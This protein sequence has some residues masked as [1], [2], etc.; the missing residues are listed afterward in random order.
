MQNGKE[1][2]NRWQSRC[3]NAAVLC[4]ILTVV[5]VSHAGT[6]A[7][8]PYYIVLCTDVSGSMNEHDPLYRDYEGK[9]ST[10]RDDAQTTFLGLLREF[11]SETYVGVCKFTDR[12]TEALPGGT[13][14]RAQSKDALLR[15]QEVGSDWQDLREKINTQRSGSGGTRIEKALTWAH[16]RISSAREQH[17][18][19]GHGIV[20]L[21]SDGD[22]DRAESRSKNELVVNTAREL[23]SDSIS[24]YPIIINRA[25]HR[26][27]KL[28]QALT[29]EDLAAEKLMERVGACSRTQ[30][31]RITGT[32]DLLDIFLDILQV[33]PTPSPIPS[34]ES[35]DVS[36]HHRTVVFIGPALKSVV[37][38]PN[39]S[40]PPQ[41]RHELLLKN[42]HDPNSAIELQVVPLARWNIFVLR[43][44]PDLD[45]IDRYWTGTWQPM[46]ESAR[47]DGRVYLITDFLARLT[48]E[49]VSPVWVDERIRVGAL[50]TERPREMA[51]PNSEVPPL[52]SE[53]LSFSF[54]TLRG[55]R[56]SPIEVPTD[57]WDSASKTYW[58]QPFQVGA[59]GDYTV[60]CDCF[61]HSGVQPV[62]LDTFSLDLPVEPPPLSM[63][64]RKTQ[65]EEVVFPKA[66][67]AASEVAACQGGEQL[68]A[69]LQI[70][71]RY[72]QTRIQAGYLYLDIKPSQQ[73]AFQWDNDRFITDAFQLPE[74]DTRLA[75]FAQAT[76]D[77][78]GRLRELRLPGNGFVFPFNP[79]PLRLA[80][81][82][83]DKRDALWWGERHRQTVD[84][85]VYPVFDESAETITGLFP[86]DLTQASMTFFRGPDRDSMVVPLRCT[87]ETLTK[88][89]D[90]GGAQ[91]I[92]GRYRFE[93]NEPI[94]PSRRCTIDLGTVLT[95]LN[96]AITSY[97][98]VDPVAQDI[99]AYGMFQAARL[100]HTG[101]VADTVYTNEPISFV[102]NWASNQNVEHIAFAVYDLGGADAQ[103]V[104]EV[105][106]PLAQTQTHSEIKHAIGGLQGGRNY[107]VQIFTTLTPKGLEGPLTLALSG[108][109]FRAQKRHLELAELVVKP[110]LGENVSCY[111]LEAI[112]LPLQIYFTGYAADNSRHRQRLAEF[113]S[114]CRL[115]VGTDT[116]LQ[117]DI[118]ETIEWITKSS[119]NAA[120]LAKPYRM[121][122]RAR[123]TPQ[124][125]GLHTL[126]LS[127]EFAVQ[128]ADNKLHNLHQTSCRLPVKPPRF[129]VRVEE[130]TPRINTSLFDSD[131]LVAGGQPTVP[132]RNA[133]AT[134]LRVYLDFSKTTKH[135]P[136]LSLPVG[137]ALN[138]Q[139]P[140]VNRS[141]RV[142]Y[143]EALVN[144]SHNKLALSI[145]NPPLQAEGAYSLHVFAL[146]PGQDDPRPE[147]ITPALVTIMGRAD[148]CEVVA[149]GGFITHGVRQWPFVYHV[150]IQDSWSFSPM[151]LRFEFQFSGMEDTWL[152][153]SMSVDPESRYVVVRSPEILPGLER[154]SSGPMQFRLRY[155]GADRVTWESR[156]I[157]QVVKPR[158]ENV[159]VV[160]KQKQNEQMLGSNL[161]QAP[162]SLRLRPSFRQAPE[163][164][165]WWSPKTIKAWTIRLT[166]YDQ[167]TTGLSSDLVRWLMAWQSP[168]AIAGSDRVE[169][170]VLQTP[171]DIQEGIEIL[172]KHYRRYRFWG[173]PRFVAGEARY[174]T[175]ISA[176]YE[177][178]NTAAIPTETED[179]K[180][181]QNRVIT[182][183]SA[184][185]I[186]R[187]EKPISIP[188]FWWLLGAL[189]CVGG[190]AQTIRLY[191]VP[192]PEDLGL[193]VRLLSQGSVIDPHGANPL[194]A[195]LKEQVP[196][197]REVQLVAADLHGRFSGL[198][199]AAPKL[200]AWVKVFLSRCFLARR[201]IWV[202]IRPRPNPNATDVKAA[203]MGVW[204]DILQRKGIVWSS[205]TGLDRLPEKNKMSKIAFRLTRKV[206][207]IERALSVVVQI[208]R[209]N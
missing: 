185:R 205:E 158:L 116:G 147:L 165:D 154:V 76:L 14:A 103:Q 30:S 28:T 109:T 207:G 171:R 61:D 200:L 83:S 177:E 41:K 114:S 166:D 157:V 170:Q 38:T 192:A 70:A 60:T 132:A 101:G 32:V 203:L 6:R 118:T 27:G 193:S 88:E 92:I 191:W 105:N 45:Q 34:A 146:G 127:S 134:R 90:K 195:N 79:A 3:L 52:L 72:A 39:G 89:G 62:L 186:I 108:G 85:S 50:L 29:D 199:K 68:Y 87:L 150:P 5:G 117:H 120:D 179:G 167:Q 196:W 12:I 121:K 22:P 15:W 125:T 42:G 202:Q 2:R 131:K 75:G 176:S 73:L 111:A 13:S 48:V 122:G 95:G 26:S 53:D 97:D 67:D 163:L 46:S 183:W 19:Q 17:Q 137:I 74:G 78:K 55:G 81:G 209:S 8:T 18:A 63:V 138:Q 198:G 57:K 164:I 119:T 136:A 64:L 144:T 148:P 169:L 201:G 149:P 188:V 197:A 145:D 84:I 135:M 36:K 56:T 140:L 173:W 115:T 47:Y 37:I 178:S 10:F 51:E 44:P 58:S 159:Q 43:R 66:G 123:F 35:F 168:G 160:L 24:I 71:Q 11:P 182:E 190:L 93:C 156:N 155:L 153:G 23:A 130:L 151:D 100:R 175:L 80:C 180:H 208:K 7:R 77:T 126:K 189:L 82:F 172:S 161:I 91:K 21:L 40:P 128:D 181:V 31:Y 96:A 65:T 106:L 174:A 206:D 194:T 142:F 9:L 112:E 204:T 107:G 187:V 16:Q 1:I 152:Q 98:V 113:K 99:F 86:N 104:A 141:E 102:A 54:S 4:F 124:R 162:F 184:P 133:Y 20:I 49:P 33:M 129:S 110:A 69:E 59:P 143:E 25:S 94:P 139:N